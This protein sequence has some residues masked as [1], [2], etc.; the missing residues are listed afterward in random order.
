[1]GP[2]GG[3]GLRSGSFPSTDYQQTKRIN[4]AAAEGLATR[5]TGGA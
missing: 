1:M 2:E 3:D 5:Y 4:L